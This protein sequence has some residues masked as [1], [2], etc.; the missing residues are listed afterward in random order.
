LCQQPL[1]LLAYSVTLGICRH[2][3]Q[4]T[5][6]DPPSLLKPA[7]VKKGRR[8]KTTAARKNHFKPSVV[9]FSAHC[10]TWQDYVFFERTFTTQIQTNFKFT[11]TDKSSIF[12]TSVGTII[13]QV[14]VPPLHYIISH[15]AAITFAK[16]VELWYVIL[17]RDDH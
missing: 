6:P 2:P 4:I 15:R 1:R 12:T 3:R 14:Q 8:E 5:S 7:L 10:T 13:G 9:F 16:V 17:V 11:R